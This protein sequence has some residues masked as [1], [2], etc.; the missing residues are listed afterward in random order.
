MFKCPEWQVLLYT[1]TISVAFSSVHEVGRGQRENG[2]EIYK[3]VCLKKHLW[4]RKKKTPKR[5][6]LV[7]TTTSS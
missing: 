4:L 2:E 3:C 1:L 6:L 7:Y 5:R